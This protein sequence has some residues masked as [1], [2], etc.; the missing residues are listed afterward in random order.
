MT[1]R[2]GLDKLA[3]MPPA[4][5][6]ALVL[7]G[8]VIAAS[9]VTVAALGPWPELAGAADSTGE[10]GRLRALSLL[11]VGLAAVAGVG[12]LVL[13]RGV[14]R[15]LAAFARALRRSARTGL[16]DSAVPALAPVSPELG[17]AADELLETLHKTRRE[18]LRAM[19][20]ASAKAEQQKNRLETILRDLG[21]GVLVC[22]DDHRLSLYNQAALRILARPEAVGLGRPLFE[23]LAEGPIRHAVERLRGRLGSSA[24]GRSDG[25]VVELTAA[26]TDGATPLH[27][28]MSPILEPDGSMTGYV[29]SFADMTPELPERARREALLGSIAGELDAA[30]AALRNAVEMLAAEPVPPPAASRRAVEE[31]RSAAARLQ[32][33]HARLTAETLRLAGPLRF[34]ADV[35]SDELLAALA[36]HLRESDGIT[37]GLTGAAHRLRGDS[38][39]LLLGLAHLVRRLPREPGAARLEAGTS[40]ADGR[41]HLDIRTSGPPPAPGCLEAWLDEP[42]PGLV[43]GGSA[44]SVFDGHGALLGSEAPDAGGTRLRLS[45]PA[46]P[47]RPPEAAREPLP[48]RP[49]FYDFDLIRR[50][51][52]S[53]MRG[54]TSLRALS[55]VVFDTETTG[56]RPS[57]GDEIVSIA[58]VRVV[59]GRVL[60]GETFEQLVNPGRPIPRASMRFH[61][62]TDE[63][64]RDRPRLAGVLPA[65]KAFVGESV[66]VAHNAAFDLKFLRLKEAACGVTFDNPVIDTL[67]LSVFLHGGDIGHSLDELAE[68][69]QVE[70]PGRH[71]AL[72]DALATAGVFARMIEVLEARNIRTLEDAI[73]ASNMLAE[74]RRMEAEF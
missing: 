29:L 54:R 25:L 28:R 12:W 44:R 55:Y 14:T 59:N 46:P 10:A 22:T 4:R 31:A 37:L 19:A 9:V 56:L 53:P 60:T 38:Y 20:T 43:G 63:M 62:I 21:E 2:D 69:Y 11:V 39:A 50:E 6:F 65:F 58:G 16:A 71:T 64:V 33:Q 30:L 74:L 70:V 49:E 15:R 1:S 13:Q 48:P 67:L 61:G 3:A 7:T 27:A 72:G 66:L 68:A 34:A 57:A 36:R 41:I 24:S 47:Q 42:L 26:T 17:A 8:A 32:D 35:P 73:E 52:V 45:F 40:E 23:L 51:R 5:L 18:I